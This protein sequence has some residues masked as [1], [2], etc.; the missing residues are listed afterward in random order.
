M[1]NCPEIM[2]WEVGSRR[3]Y[4]YCDD[5]IELLINDRELLRYCIDESKAMLG[6]YV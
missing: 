3:N 5:D 6:E 4:G 2:N 1:E